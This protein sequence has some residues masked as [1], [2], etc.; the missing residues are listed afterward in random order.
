MS[1]EPSGPHGENRQRNVYASGM[2]ADDPP[3]HPVR[4]EDLEREALDEMSDEAAA[5]VAGGAGTE[6]TVDENR[7]A[8]AD[9]RIVP[10]MLRD[11]SERDLRVDLFD[12]AFDLPVMLAPLG[13]L[14]I[15]HEEGELAVARAAADLDVPMVLSSASSYT[16]EAVAE[17]LG[18][19]PKWFQLYWSADPAIAS[20]FIDRAESAG[21]D[22]IVVTLDTPLLGWRERDIEQGYLPFLDGEGVANY[23]SDP[24][25][26]ERLDVSPEENEGSAVMEFID[27]FGDPS[28]TWDDLADLRAETDLPLIVK[29]VLHP[30]DAERA[31]ECGADGVIVSNHGGRQVDGAIGALAALPSVVEAIEDTPVLFDSGIRSG[32]DAVKALALGADA[33]LLGR[34]Y[35]YGLALDGEAGVRSVLENFRADL[36]LTLALAGHTSFDDLDRSVLADHRPPGVDGP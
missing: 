23:F 32:A 5:Y 1:E 20:S 36:D 10:R 9:W 26:R 25:F 27:V 33:V 7:R 13:V 18:E 21:Y 4:Y 24:A 34:P 22:G 3:E 35:A 11:V 17:E 14:S 29:G 19:T 31:V 15:V 12:T 8:F 6:D 30:D 16:M 2:L 28:L